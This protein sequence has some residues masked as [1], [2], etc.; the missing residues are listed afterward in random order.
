MLTIINPTILDD[1]PAED[2]PSGPSVHHIDYDQTTNTGIKGTSENRCLD[3]TYRSHSDWLFG[4]LR[5]KSRMNTLKAILEEAKVKGGEAE[6]DGRRVDDAEWL[7]EGWLE[8]TLNG[9]VVESFADAVK[10]WQS[11]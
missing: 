5:G 4:D 7:A 8:E 1:G 9:E 6:E 3:W 10:G 11:W 2:N